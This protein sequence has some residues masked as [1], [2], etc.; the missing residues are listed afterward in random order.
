SPIVLAVEIIF[1]VAGV[2][3]EFGSGR[4]ILISGGDK[5]PIDLSD[6]PKQVVYRALQSGT[7]T[8]SINVAGDP[9][10][11]QVNGVDRTAEVHGRLH[12]HPR[13]RAAGINVLLI[14]EVDSGF[15]C[16]SAS[17]Q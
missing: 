16:V 9:E 4:R 1:A 7:I 14:A 13:F 10:C 3:I 12:V 6:T 8:R 15:E 5:T 17:N 2:K 11:G